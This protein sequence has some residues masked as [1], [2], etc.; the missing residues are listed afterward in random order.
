MPESKGESVKSGAGKTS[1]FL[2]N[3]SWRINTWIYTWLCSCI[4][5]HHVTTNLLQSDHTMR[6]L[7][8][9][10]FTS[11]TLDWLV[12]SSIIS[13]KIIWTQATQESNIVHGLQFS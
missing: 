12:G 10:H 11:T 3:E 7:I 9:T 6:T 5:S 2:C 4:E 1:D 8:G 13:S